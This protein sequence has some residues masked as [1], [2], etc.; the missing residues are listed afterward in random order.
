MIGISFCFL[1][2]VVTIKSKEREEYKNGT[3][4]YDKIIENE[5][6][7]TGSI[8]KGTYIIALQITSDENKI[9]LFGVTQPSFTLEEVENLENSD[10]PSYIDEYTSKIDF[11]V[12]LL[13]KYIYI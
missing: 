10:L 1:L 5:H 11:K 6:K 2:L 8:D 13:F 9:V 3:D 4:I 7:L 12:I